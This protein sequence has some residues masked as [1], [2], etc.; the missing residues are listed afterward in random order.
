MAENVQSDQP[1]GMATVDIGSNSASVPDV[2]YEGPGLQRDRP[3]S[4]SQRTTASTTSKTSR[5]PYIYHTTNTTGKFF[6]YKV[7]LFYH[8][9]F[10]IT[11]V[12]LVRKHHIV[13]MCL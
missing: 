11:E 12:F 2:K 8:N 7:G 1:S 6:S 9:F 3:F 13:V 10:F 4:A 5:S